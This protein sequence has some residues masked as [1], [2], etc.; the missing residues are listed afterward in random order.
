M[1]SDLIAEK[2]KFTNSNSDCS[3]TPE[4]V[5]EFQDK[6]LISEDAVKR[7]TP[8]WSGTHYLDLQFLLNLLGHLHIV[9]KLQG[10]EFDR[11]TETK[12][13]IPC[14]LA[15]TLYN[16][17]KPED[18]SEPI[19][20]D[21]L[22][23]FD[24][25]DQYCPK[26]LFSIF[27]IKL[28]QKP[29]QDNAKYTWVLNHKKLSEEGVVFHVKVMDSGSRYSYTLHIQHGLVGS[30]SMLRI[31]IEKLCSCSSREQVC[32]GCKE[33]R[34]SVKSAIKSSLNELHKSTELCIGFYSTCGKNKTSSESH[35]AIVEDLFQQNSGV[36]EDMTC[37][38]CRNKSC[39]LKEEH[40]VWFKEVRN[41]PCNQIITFHISTIKHRGYCLVHHAIYCGHYSRAAFIKLSTSPQDFF[42]KYW[43][44]EEL[45]MLG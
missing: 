38:D 8:Q 41:A 45:V 5:E 3:L 39:P 12:Y 7:I 4:Q 33:I 24:H 37:I 10:D 31:F 21:L 42:V 1:L 11:K 2:F 22:I 9:L 29:K 30:R 32:C 17:S 44:W 27:V 6:G 15:G 43:L 35:I 18:I 25:G 28:A 36:P 26:G 23:L 20:A 13:F 40:K 34:D 14:V 16:L 19:V